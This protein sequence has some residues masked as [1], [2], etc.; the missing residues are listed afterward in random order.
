M[1]LF[2]TFEGVEGCGKSVQAKALYRRLAQL[3]L[4]AVLTQE[5]GGTALGRKIARWLK[6]AE[7]TDISPLSEL[8]L[9]NAS[10]S[11]L[12]SDVIKPGLGVGKMVICDRY[13]DSTTA[14]QSYGRGLDLE[15]V[16]AVNRAATHGLEPHLT[17]LLDI[18][19]EAGL[20]RKG[21]EK[22]DRF[23]RENMDFHRR[24]RDGYLKIAADDPSR[25]LVIDASQSKEKIRDIIWQRVSQ[26]L[27]ERG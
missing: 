7:N 25:W 23:E 2:I 20:A 22:Q 14:Y 1:S 5:P 6:W 13:T 10:R 9:F 16:K 15:M 11:Q 4:P 21:A 8:F 27:S 3:A 12:M 19:V 17:F 18:T 24:V 26:L